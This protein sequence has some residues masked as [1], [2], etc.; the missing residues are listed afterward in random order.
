MTEIVTLLFRLL[1]A[2]A[3]A[4][5]PFQGPVMAKG[6]N[7]H[8]WGMEFPQGQKYVPCWPYWMTAHALIAGGGV[9]WATGIVG[10]GVLETALHWFVDFSKC[11]NW[12]GPHED[13]AIHLFCRAC[14][15]GLFLLGRIAT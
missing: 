13:Q 9:Y 4:D 12:T 11:E 7:R 1:V 15:I 3:L 8:S 10:F 2:H 14:Y 5:F 6:K